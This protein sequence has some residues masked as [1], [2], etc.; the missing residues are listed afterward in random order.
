MP[1]PQPNAEESKDKYMAKCMSD[2]TMNEEHPNQDKRYAICISTW[3]SNKYDKENKQ[4][5]RNVLNT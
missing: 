1:I 2:K 4:N 5:N 3:S